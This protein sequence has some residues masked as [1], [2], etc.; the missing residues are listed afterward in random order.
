MTAIDFENLNGSQ[1]A[2]VVEAIRLSFD[3]AQ[4]AM[5]LL[6][7]L[8]K[9]LGDLAEPG[10]WP[11]RVFRTV[12]ESQKEG[13]GGQLI[14][15]LEIE[16]PDTK[17][18]TA[19]RQRLAEL[20]EPSLAS[21]KNE[22]TQEGGSSAT[23]VSGTR[24]ANLEA[25]AKSGWA[26]HWAEKS[27]T[28]LNAMTGPLLVL[29]LGVVAVVAYERA[30]PRELTI[31]EYDKLLD[32]A[33][34]ELNRNLPKEDEIVV[35]EKAKE[36]VENEQGRVSITTKFWP[37][38]TVPYALSDTFLDRENALAAVAEY[39][40]KTNVRF[41]E[42]TPQNASNYPDYVLF[43]DSGAC[44]SWVGVQ[45]GEQKLGIG[46]L[47]DLGS[48]LHEIGHTLGMYHEQSR[49]DRDNYVKLNL[50]NVAPGATRDFNIVQSSVNQR[51]P[52]DYESIMHFQPTAF[53]V[54]GKPTIEPLLSTARIGPTGHLS[55]GD[56]LLINAIYSRPVSGT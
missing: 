53:S 51:R 26:R 6:M 44:Y 34:D 21:D 5:L 17:R 43:V 1:I 45:G 4:F 46:S 18:I 2:A 35:E 3:E 30:M 50:E 56:I 15:A 29:M 41:I 19:L 12:A 22:N 54:N 28:F 11:E 16:R 27:R 23:K 49:P 13:F 42:R 38:S 14:D 47:C 48:V 8:N 9:E 55:A 32:K 31:E 37:N 33:R 36:K 52:Y 10:T 7:R 40:Q 24:S 25:D 20:Q 39:Q